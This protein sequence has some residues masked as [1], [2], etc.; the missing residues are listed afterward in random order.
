M[1]VFGG[2]S[3]QK[4]FLWHQNLCVDTTMCG[5]NYVVLELNG[6]EINFNL[7]WFVIGLIQ[8]FSNNYTGKVFSKFKLM[9]ILQIT[10]I[11]AIRLY[12]IYIFFIGD[13][14]CTITNVEHVKLQNQ[15]LMRKSI[16]ADMNLYKN[17]I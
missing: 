9:S 16:V 8:V 11:P 1:Q 10:L 7:G 4:K 5:Y 12:D 3:H 15:K 6:W 14:I 13:T 2:V 17:I